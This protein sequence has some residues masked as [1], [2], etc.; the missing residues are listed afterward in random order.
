MAERMGAG[1]KPRLR[2]LHWQA[3]K[4]P[5][6]CKD[7][8]WTRLA[9]PHCTRN[10]AGTRTGASGDLRKK[11]RCGRGHQSVRGRVARV[12]GLNGLNPTHTRRW[13]RNE[14]L[15]LNRQSWR[16]PHE[17]KLWPCDGDPRVDIARATL[18]APGAFRRLGG[19]EEGIGL[20][21]GSGLV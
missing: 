16:A 12:S 4:A 10:G 2:G 19:T 9:L 8:D 3:F 21:P 5:S 6:R 20:E 1:G 17:Q 11:N 14:R 15:R 7:K 18:S 13:I